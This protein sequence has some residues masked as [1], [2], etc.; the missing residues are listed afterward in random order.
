MKRLPNYLRASR[1]RLAL[2]QHEAAFLAGLYRGSSIS[3]YE[4]SEREPTLE[5]ALALEVIFQRPAKE[6]FPDL[7]RKVEREVMA[8]AKTLI[9]KTDRDRP[10]LGTTRKRQVLLGL[11]NLESDNA[12]EI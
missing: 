8:R 12:N 1:K 4:D 2:S 3:R 7:Y 10:N 6:L 11:V 9:Y 5:K